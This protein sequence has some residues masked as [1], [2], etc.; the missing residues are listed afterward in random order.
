VD[1]LQFLAHPLGDRHGVL[2]GARFLQAQELKVRWMACFA[3]RD[4]TPHESSHRRVKDTLQKRQESVQQTIVYV[5][6]FTGFWIAAA[7]MWADVSL[8]FDKP[9]KDVR[10]VRSAPYD[11]PRC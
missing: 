7:A 6:V 10:I 3:R 11:L 9:A 5:I 1:L 2:S 8:S 4:F